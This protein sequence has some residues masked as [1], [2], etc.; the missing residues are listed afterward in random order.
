[1]KLQAT[2]N[3]DLL[4]ALSVTLAAVTTKKKTE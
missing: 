2:M 4:S 3:P 1:M